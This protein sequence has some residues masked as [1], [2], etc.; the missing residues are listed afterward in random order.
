M[1]G[2][3]S[4]MTIGTR[5]LRQEVVHLPAP[6]GFDWERDGMVVSDSD[7]ACYSRPEHG[8]NVLVGS[9]D[10]PCDGH[11]WVEDDLHLDRDFT[12]Q[13]QVQALR[14][15]QRVPSLGIPSRMRGVADLYDV[16]DD[17]IPIYDRSDLDGFYMAVGTSGNQFKNAA[18][19]GHLLAEVIGACQQGHDH[20]AD[21]VRVKTRYTGLELNAGFYSRNREINPA[22]S[23]S[24]N[25]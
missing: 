19:V 2:A 4:D 1:A 15:A 10:P 23:F 7:I 14:F 13:W 25:G 20:D 9:E 3:T 5:A 22:S 24:V 17:W 12:E 18:G 16:S 6:P 21:P 8:N 11:V